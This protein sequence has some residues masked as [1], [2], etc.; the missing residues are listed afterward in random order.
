MDKNRIENIL[1]EIC[2]LQ[3]SLNEKTTKDWIKSSNDYYRA[4]WMEASELMEHFGYKWWKHQKPV[5]EQCK[6]EL[7]DILHFLVSEL[8]KDYE[9]LDE[10]VDSYLD[11]FSDIVTPLADIDNDAESIRCDIEW[12]VK[13]LIDAELLDSFYFLFKLFFVFGLNLEEIYIK[14]IG[15]YTLNIFRQNNGYK[16]GYYVKIWDGKEDNE[17]LTSILKNNENTLLS[18]DFTMDTKVSLL[19]HELSKKYPF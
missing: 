6:M 12:L 9:K 18:E 8:I 2:T 3:D 1:S 11:V 14:Y 19:T 4:A 5:I 15:K 16:E 13:N 10:V 17:V 7:I